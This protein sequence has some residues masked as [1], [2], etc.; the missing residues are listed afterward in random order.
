MDKFT[1]NYGPTLDLIAASELLPLLEA[2]TGKK[3][4]IGKYK[5]GTVLRLLLVTGQKDVFGGIFQRHYAK[6]CEEQA[7]KPNRK[8]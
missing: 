2:I 4:A 5:T 6:I 7:P 3:Q 1:R 8:R